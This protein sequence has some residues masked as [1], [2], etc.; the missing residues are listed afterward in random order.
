METDLRNICIFHEDFFPWNVQLQNGGRAVIFF[1]CF[2]ECGTK[3][4][5]CS[6]LIDG[7]HNCTLYMKCCVSICHT[8]GDISNLLSTRDNFN[9]HKV[10][11]K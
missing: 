9:L 8:N 3:Y 7:E 1:T 5:K 4:V 2:N 11:I 6:T 10:T